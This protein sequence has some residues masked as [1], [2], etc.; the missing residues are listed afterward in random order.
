[1]RQG[2]AI[3]EQLNL[4]QAEFKDRFVDQAQTRKFFGKSMWNRDHEMHGR[5]TSYHCP[6]HI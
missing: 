1:M 6:I 4:L 3:V 2:D 5:V